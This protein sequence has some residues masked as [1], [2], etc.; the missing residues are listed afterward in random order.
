MDDLQ[1]EN[2]ERPWVTAILQIVLRRR[3]LLLEVCEDDLLPDLLRGRGE[4]F[5]FIDGTQHGVVVKVDVERG[6]LSALWFRRTI[7]IAF[8]QEGREPGA[9]G[10]VAGRLPFAREDLGVF[11]ELM[12]VDDVG[13]RAQFV[14]GLERMVALKAAFERQEKVDRRGEEQHF[15]HAGIDALG[16]IGDARRELAEAEKS[17]DQGDDRDT[18]EQDAEN[19]RRGAHPAVGAGQPAGAFRRL[20]DVMSANSALTRLR[21]EFRENV[22]YAACPQ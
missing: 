17:V 1:E 5:H 11:G 13:E 9:R 3:P 7:E 21:P 20:S 16:E 10:R 19:D 18:D 22:V 4:V 2:E 15:V 12:H 6:D 8:E 14:Q